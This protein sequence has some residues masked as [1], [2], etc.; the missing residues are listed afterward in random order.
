MKTPIGSV[1]NDTSSSVS[2][3]RILFTVSTFGISSCRDNDVEECALEASD[4]L[5]IE[6]VYFMK[7]KTNS[8]TFFHRLLSL[9][10]A[11]GVSMTS[12]QTIYVQYCPKRVP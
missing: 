9:S 12:N 3:N 11:M 6:H 4:K 2:D 1:H 5:D 8:L 10:T 7:I